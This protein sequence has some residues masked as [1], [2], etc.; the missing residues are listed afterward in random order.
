MKCLDTMRVAGTTLCLGNEAIYTCEKCEGKECEG[1]K[2]IPK[3]KFV[4]KN[5]SQY[6]AYEPYGE[7]DQI[8]EIIKKKEFLFGVGVGLLLGALIFRR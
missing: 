3:P 1:C 7:F 4:A 5:Q 6:G 8:M 2:P